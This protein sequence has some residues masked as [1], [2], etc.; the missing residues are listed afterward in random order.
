MLAKYEHRTFEEGCHVWISRYRNL[1]NIPH[2]HFES[3]LITCEQ[4]S[5]TVM[6]DGHIY[7]LQPGWC[8][9]CR[10]EGVHYISSGEGTELI[11]AQFNIKPLGDQRPAEPL[12]RDRYNLLA[13]LERI[14][15]EYRHK[16][17]YYAEKINALLVNAI[18]DVARGEK[19][20]LD[21]PSESPSIHRYKQLLV[22]IDESADDFTFSQAAAYMNMSEAYFSRFFKRMSGLTFSRYL[23]VVRI[24]RALEVMNAQPDITMADLMSRCGFNTLR[25]FNRVF[26]DVTGF[27][28]SR[29]PP[30]FTLDMRSLAT[31][32]GSF[33]PTL[34]TSVIIG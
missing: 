27:A 26:K 21:T 22:K 13:Q 20:C 29:L 11:V 15:T 5:A 1:H 8:L 10:P 25:N 19:M 6:L 17:P 30:G 4:G 12:F 18:V 28:P 7:D 16:P 32:E 9:Y 24:D 2:W 33:D 31:G 34:D 3:E 23:N 14:N